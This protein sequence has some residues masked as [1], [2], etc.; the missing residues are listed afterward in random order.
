MSTTR[1]RPLRQ[2]AWPRVQGCVLPSTKHSRPGPESSSDTC[3]RRRG[4]H[5]QGGQSDGS[6]G[7]RA[8]MARFS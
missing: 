3:S 8:Y 7:K 6:N 2:H 5:R 4:G 1:T